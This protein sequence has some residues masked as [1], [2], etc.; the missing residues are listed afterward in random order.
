MAVRHAKVADWLVLFTNPEDAV[1]ESS[2]DASLIAMDDDTLAGVISVIGH[3][4]FPRVTFEQLDRIGDAFLPHEYP[5]AVITA[6]RS[7]RAVLRS[8]EWMGARI[9]DF[10]SERLDDALDWLQVPQAHRA[11]IAV[12]ITRLRDKSNDESAGAA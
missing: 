12:T 8:F 4:G 10:S 3:D 2:F 6:H 11:D 5:V 7:T 1:G 9:R